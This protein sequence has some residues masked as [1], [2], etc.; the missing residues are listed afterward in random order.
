MGCPRY[1]GILNISGFICLCR[2]EEGRMSSE[3]VRQGDVRVEN[4]ARGMQ[5]SVSS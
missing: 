2:L 5:L 1:P 3:E 4:H